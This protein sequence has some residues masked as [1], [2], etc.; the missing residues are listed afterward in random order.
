MA[1]PLQKLFCKTFFWSLYA[2]DKTGLVEINDHPLL[3]RIDEYCVQNLDEITSIEKQT[4]N[5]RALR[6]LL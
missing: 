3:C 6:K 2:L 1:K 5:E 4:R